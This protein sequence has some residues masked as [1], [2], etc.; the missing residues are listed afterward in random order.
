[1]R[2]K[3]SLMKPFPTMPARGILPL[4]TRPVRA[5][6]RVWKIADCLHEKKRAFSRATPRLRNSSLFPLVRLPCHHYQSTASTHIF[7][8]M[9][10]LCWQ[11]T[12]PDLQQRRSGA[13]TFPS[14]CARR[15]FTWNAR[16]SPTNLNFPNRYRQKYCQ[17][18]TSSGK[19]IPCSLRLP[20]RT[21]CA[22]A[23]NI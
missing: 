4:L 9:S 3:D 13:A 10:A 2:Q 17:Q 8:V 18:I 20:G 16:A 22:H 7:N 23:L 21:F 12:A 5:T 1:M 15:A 6:A 19:A 11:K 14:G